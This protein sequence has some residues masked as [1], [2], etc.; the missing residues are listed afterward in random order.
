MIAMISVLVVVYFLVGVQVLILVSRYH[1]ARVPDGPQFLLAWLLWPVA[2][3]WTLIEI[4]TTEL[5][6]FINKRATTDES[7]RTKPA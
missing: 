1:H 2:G 3:V 6:L 7:D 5:P 4:I